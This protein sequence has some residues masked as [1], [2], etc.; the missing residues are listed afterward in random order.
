MREKGVSEKCVRIVN[1]MY[2]EATTQVR[3][4][5]GTTENFEVKVGLHQ[6]SALSPYIFDMVM[7]VIVEEVKDQVPWSVLFADDI[8]LVTTSKEEAERKL[9]LW[10]VALEDRGLKISRA[11]TEYMWMNGEDQDGSIY[12]QQ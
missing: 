6:G 4:S 9:E 12:L 3:S 7:D 2:R 10:R 11:K 8:V 5:V 1:D